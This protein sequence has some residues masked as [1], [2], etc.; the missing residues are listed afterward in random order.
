M[1]FQERLPRGALLS[2]WRRFCA[3]PFQYILDRVRC[4][5]VANIGQCTLYSIITPGG[6]LASM[7]NT[8]SVILPDTGS[9]WPLP[10]IGP[11]P[12][13]ELAMPGKQCVRGHERVNFLE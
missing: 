6:V 10:G 12:G 11:L 5:S 3:M 9:A 8:K 4:N 13:Y 7:L 1:R 2:L